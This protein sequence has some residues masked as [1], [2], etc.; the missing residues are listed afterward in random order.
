MFEPTRLSLATA[1]ERAERAAQALAADPRVKLVMLFGSVVDPG[2]EVVHDV[3]LAVQTDPPLSLDELMRLRADVVDSAGP[4]IDLV[5]LDGAPILLKRDAVGVGGVEGGP[6][7]TN[8]SRRIALRMKLSPA[9]SPYRSTDAVD[10]RRKLYFA[11]AL[12][13]SSQDAHLGAVP[14]F[15]PTGGST[16]GQPHS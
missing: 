9:A 10:R 8:F 12:R 5:S 1:R 14:F 11:T 13:S 6:V 16:D 4:G 2:R 7:P 15:T 3:D